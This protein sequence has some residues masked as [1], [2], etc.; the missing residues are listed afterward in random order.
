MDGKPLKMVS[1][2]VAGIFNASITSGVFPVGWKEAKVIPL[3]KNTNENFSGKKQS[4]RPISLL[5]IPSNLLE[6]IV[7]DQMQGC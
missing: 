4:K 2:V 7:T 1:S 6:K 3:P 5:L